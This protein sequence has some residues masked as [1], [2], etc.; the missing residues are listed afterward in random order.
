MTSETDLASKVAFLREA[1]SYPGPPDSVEAIETHMAWVFLAGAFAYK[2]KKPVRF[3]YLDF[4]TLERRRDDC[5]EEVRLNRRLADGVYVG[6]VPLCTTAE[7]H[8]V[9]GGEGKVVD[10][11]VQMRRLPTDKMLDVCIRNRTYTEADIR[12]VA[13]ILADFYRSAIPETISAAAYRRRFAR[14]VESNAS[15]LKKP[16]YDTPAAAVNEIISQQNS[17]LGN[18]PPLFDARVINR[19]IVEGHGDLRPDH[20]CLEPHPVIFD[21]LEFKRMFRIVDPAD[22]LAFLSMESERLGAAE[23][24]TWLFQ[25]YANQTG[26]RP[27]DLLIRFYKSC[28]SCLRARLSAQHLDDEGVDEAKW[29][30]RTSAYLRLGLTYLST[31]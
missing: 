25:E 22:E 16:E 27:P 11:L 15:I 26:D 19:R 13:R 18:Y 21:C 4:S 12:R 7:G 29:R 17:F 2:L 10:W 8:L 5:R 31:V 6:V 3:E 24:G 1:R 20:V 30:E 9:L 28:Q 14:Q 23:I